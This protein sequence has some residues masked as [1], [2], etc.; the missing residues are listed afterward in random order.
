MPSTHCRDLAEREK[1][2]TEWEKQ[3]QMYQGENDFLLTAVM[4]VRLGV[5]GMARKV[6]LQSFL[7]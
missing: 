7:A 1:E 5:A 4:P 3:L 2:V 6:C